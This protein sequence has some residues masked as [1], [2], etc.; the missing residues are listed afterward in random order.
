MYLGYTTTTN[1]DNLKQKLETT[2]FAFTRQISSASTILEAMF[3]VVARK[4]N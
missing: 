2:L 1:N 4:V 3:F